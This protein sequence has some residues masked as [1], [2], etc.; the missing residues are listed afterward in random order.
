VFLLDPLANYPG[1]VLDPEAAVAK[2]PFFGNEKRRFSSHKYRVRQ[3]R[4]GHNQIPAQP[5]AAP[6]RKSELPDH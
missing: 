5:A 4:K 6:L 1:M 3:R 2:K